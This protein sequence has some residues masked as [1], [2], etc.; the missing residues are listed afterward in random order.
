MKKSIEENS[1]RAGYYTAKLITRQYAK[2]FY[3]ASRF[4]TKE[5]RNAAYSIYAACRVSDDS[6]DNP[7]DSPSPVRLEQINKKINAAY[8]NQEAND[9]LLLAFKDTICRYQIP[10][11]YFDE[12]IEGMYMDLHKNRYKDFEELYTYCYKVAGVVGLIM[13]NVFGYTN[14]E[15]AK[16]SVDLGIAMQLTNILR[17]IKEDYRRGRIYLPKDEMARFGVS[18][19]HIAEGKVDEN[20]I[21]LL[22][23]QIQRAKEYYH[24]S[25]K[26]IK[27][28]SDEQ[29][30]S[31]L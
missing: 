19:N 25:Y 20:F 1:I 4:L 10:K 6:V 8:R 24:N 2:T 14:Q 13:L 3:F 22:R 26:G 30:Q 15:A 12:L 18:E 23:L 29:W 11:R 21:A 31:S 5:K 9:S 7:E 17:D 28:I 27:M 16:Y